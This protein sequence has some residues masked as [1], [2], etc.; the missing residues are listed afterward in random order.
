MEINKIYNEDCLLTMAKMPD[1]FIDATVCSPPYDLIRDYKGFTFEFEKIAVELFRVTKDGGIVVW[2]V[3]DGTENGSETLTSFKQAIFFKEVAGFKVHDTMIYQKSGFNF[4]ANNR[5][6][7]VFEYMFV[8]SKGK[9]KT[10]NPIWDKPNKYIGQKAHGLHRGKNENEYVDMSKI[11]KAKPI[12]EFGKR[13][14]IWYYKVGGGNVTKDKIAYKHPA[15]FPEKLAQDHIISWTNPDDL[16]Y[17][18]FMGSGTVAKCCKLL[19]RR[20]IGSEISDEY[21]KIAEERL[22]NI[23]HA[24]N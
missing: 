12:G 5:Y 13:Y 4:P 22:I 14:N 19:N 3:G 18:P 2:V 21:C 16:V 8:L 9:P 24:Q 1:N 10:F 11:V 6:H 20:Y 17:D 7:Q 15:I 23:Q